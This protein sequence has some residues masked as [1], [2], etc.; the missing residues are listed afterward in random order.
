MV[1]YFLARTVPC[2]PNRKS[3][4]QCLM[5]VPRHVFK[6]Y[7]PIEKN[8]SVPIICFPSYHR[9]CSSSLILADFFSSS[10]AFCHRF[11]V[12]LHRAA[13]SQSA[14]VF[15]PSSIEHPRQA[16]FDHGVDKDSSFYGKS[17]ITD[18]LYH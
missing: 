12:P 17:H 15:R 14:Q 18:A 5:R 4:I 2:F 9:A 3:M 10:F 1:Q 8:S 13:S 11:V 6:N 16:S 7:S